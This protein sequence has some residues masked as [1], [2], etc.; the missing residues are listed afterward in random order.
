MVQ[1]RRDMGKT[2]G[3]GRYKGVEP[4]CILCLLEDRGVSKSAGGGAVAFRFDSRSMTWRRLDAAR[5]QQGKEYGGMSIERTLGSC[6]G[7]GVQHKSLGRQHHSG[8]LHCVW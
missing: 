6:G 3:K 1:W 2:E 8:Y 5:L 7:K 4:T